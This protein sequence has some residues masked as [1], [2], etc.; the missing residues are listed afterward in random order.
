[1]SKIVFLNILTNLNV[2]IWEVFLF[3]LLSPKYIFFVKELLERYVNI[4]LWLL[5]MCPDGKS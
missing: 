2:T 4:C 1:M 5:A 3:W